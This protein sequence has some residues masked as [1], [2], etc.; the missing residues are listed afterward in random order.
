[1]SPLADAIDA[2][3]ANPEQWNA[4]TSTGSTVV[5]APPGSGKTQLLTARAAFDLRANPTGPRGAACITMTNEAAM[6][7]SRRLSLF[8]VQNR[9]N[10]FVGTV[11]SFALNRIVGPFAAAAG[12]DRLA[13]STLV[14]DAEAEGVLR[15]LYLQ[16]S[17]RQE[18]FANV[19]TTVNRARQRLDLSG[20]PRLGGPAIADLA[21]KFSAQLRSADQY[22]FTELIAWAVELVEEQ[23]WVRRA[24]SACFPRVYVDEYQDLA[25]GL[26]RIVRAITIDSPDRASELFA[27][28]D[29]D[30][31]IYAFSGA[32]P[33]LLR[34]LAADS[35]T[36]TFRLRINYRSGQGVID[37]A[38]RVL[39]EDRDVAG[40][41][42]GGVIHVHE[43]R[44]GV[45]AQ[46]GACVSLV[47]GALNAGTSPEEIAVL[48]SWNS[49][50]EAAAAALRD[51]GVLCF[52]RAQLHWRSTPATVL[53]ERLAAWALRRGEA[54][55]DLGQ[56]LDR[57]P[58]VSG[59]RVNH[60]SRVEV[61][62]LLVASTAE[63]Q[64]SEF[65]ERLN[66]ALT[67][68]GRIKRALDD[69]LL[70]MVAAYSGGGPLSGATLAELALLAHAPGHVLVAT[71]HVAKGLEFDHVIVAG[72]DEQVMPG[73]NADQASWD[74]ARRL[75][76]VAITRA[77]STVDIVFTDSRWSKRNHR[78]YPVKPSPLL[79]AL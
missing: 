47:Q 48:A 40:K 13:R 74:E 77:R 69:G 6:E 78:P 53:V 33:E 54:K 72:L 37:S 5:L 43:A 70:G 55:M 67:D 71:I 36:T 28:G 46:S 51:A 60:R 10:M 2:L 57:L 41:S 32:H 16:S 19:R 8:G 38:I 39:G 18:E 30:Q 35:R 20:D 22:D 75:F 52:S 12:E 27:V 26:N 65:L 44:G 68:N 25:P 34:S 29:P 45:R 3:R 73:W 76:Y 4:F 62:R 50:R 15:T 49:D 66:A 9:P 7:M 14:S 79:R 24:L 59:A 64:V 1:M 61:T 56:L 21:R 23:A 11:H 17:L 31:S 58:V 42:T 63:T